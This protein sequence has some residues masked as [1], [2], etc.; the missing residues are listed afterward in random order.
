MAVNM[1]Q[2]RING[3]SHGISL[4]ELGYE[5]GVLHVFDVVAPCREEVAVFSPAQ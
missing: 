2:G 5:G 4:N 1:S 3:A